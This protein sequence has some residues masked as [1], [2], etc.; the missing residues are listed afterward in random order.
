MYRSV[1]GNKEFRFKYWDLPISFPEAAF[2]LVSNRNRDLWPGPTSEV[3]DSR[4]SRHSAHAQTQVWQIWLVLVSIYYVYT[5]IQ[6]RNVVGPGQGSR[7]F[8]RMTKGT[9]GDKV[10]RLATMP[11]PFFETP[12][13]PKHKTLKIVPNFLSVFIHSIIVPY[14]INYHNLR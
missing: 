1:G 13:W 5:A 10:V 6:N 4:T 11:R 8:Q 7:Y 9:A 14:Y 2:L 3:R 12:N